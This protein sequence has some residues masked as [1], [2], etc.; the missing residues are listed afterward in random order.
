MGMDTPSVLVVE[1]ESD[2]ADLYVQWLEDVCDPTAVYTGSEALASIDESIDIVL[3][4]RRMPG[5]SGDTVLD[6]IRER[7]LDCRVAMVTA[8][9]PDFDIIGM[10]FDDYIVKPVSEAELIEVVERLE[11][12]S[13]YDEQVQRFFSLAAKKTLLDAKKSDAELKTSQEYARLEDE[14]AVLRAQVDETAR[15]IFERGDYKQLCRDFGR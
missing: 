12:R 1:D 15:D 6:T 7:K 2:L 3:L 4:D 5:L 9:N 14:L 13:A 8:I 10:G 11:R